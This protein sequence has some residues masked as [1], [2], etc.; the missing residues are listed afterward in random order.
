MNFNELRENKVQPRSRPL[1]HIHIR[2]RPLCP[3]ISQI[4]QQVPDKL[5]WLT[6]L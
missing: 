4:K 5:G 3:R 6:G 1:E 2:P